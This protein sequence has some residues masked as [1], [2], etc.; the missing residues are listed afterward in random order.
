MVNE[1]YFDHLPVYH[2][3]QGEDRRMPSKLI[4]GVLRFWPSSKLTVL[5][6]LIPSR[7]SNKGCTKAKQW[8]IAGLCVQEW[9]KTITTNWPQNFFRR[10]FWAFCNCLATGFIN[11]LSRS[12]DTLRLTLSSTPSS[13]LSLRYCNAN[14]LCD[15]E[16]FSLGFL[17]SLKFCHSSFGFFL[18][19]LFF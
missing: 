11:F 3:G 6:V 12:E 5:S 18:Y 17:S 9:P 13:T 4:I 10:F 7:V 8:V 14:C 19:S 2:S 1:K 16:D 15:D